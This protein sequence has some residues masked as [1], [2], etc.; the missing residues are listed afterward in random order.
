MEAYS[1]SDWEY[2]VMMTVYCVILEWLG[3][4]EAVMVKGC[5]E[6][7]VLIMQACTFISGQTI[8]CGSRTRTQTHL[9]THM[10]IH[11][12]TYII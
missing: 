5:A 2:C 8:S 1:W 12:H 7:Q 4:H 3:V 11:T 10:H 6:F 9:S